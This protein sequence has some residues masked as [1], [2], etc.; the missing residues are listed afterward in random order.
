MVVEIVVGIP[1]RFVVKGRPKRKE[2]KKSQASL[3]L[4]RLE[5][6]PRYSSYI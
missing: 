3:L 4:T 5:G 2:K 1:I 6:E